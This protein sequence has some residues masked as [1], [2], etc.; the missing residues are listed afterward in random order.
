MMF[1]AN[2][3]SQPSI[4]FLIGTSS[5]SALIFTVHK[6]SRG[7]KPSIRN[8]LRS[9]WDI[10]TGMDA[11]KLHRRILESIRSLIPA[12]L[13]EAG[14]APQNILIGLSV[15]F[16]SSWAAVRTSERNNP[17]QTIEKSELD[18]ILQQESDKLVIF[19]RIPQIMTVNGYRIVNPVG[20]KG[21]TIQVQIRWEATTSALHKD[22]LAPFETLR[23]QDR[24]KYVSVPNAYFHALRDVTDLGD[25]VLYIDIGGEMTNVFMIADHVLSDL[26]SV[27]EGICSLVRRAA[28]ML[29]RPLDEAE[30]LI[31]RFSEGTLGESELSA[32]ANAIVAGMEEWKRQITAGLIN[33]SANAP[34]PSRLL[35]CGEGARL[36]QYKEALASS[37]YT[38]N[39]L[40]PEV[41]REQFHDFGHVQGLED[42]GLLCLAL[43]STKEIL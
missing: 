22:L 39:V 30:F 7:S 41:L 35:I 40:K 16:Y 27:P 1:G 37:E 14:H 42:V 19:S 23:L 6:E 9:S 26:L 17:Q 3:D 28:D 33:Y 11:D 12:A 5:V 36:S 29:H 31:K 8:I 2:K 24:V 4:A 34:L 18:A 38:V 25:A 21:K 10:G 32:V 15:P 20:S 13:K 43:H